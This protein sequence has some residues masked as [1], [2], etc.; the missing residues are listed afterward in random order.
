M[1]NDSPV[2]KSIVVYD[3]S[4]LYPAPLRD[5]LMWLA[6]ADLFYAKWTD[7]IHD[8]WTRSVLEDRPDLTREKLDRTRQL[9]NVKV[10]DALVVGYEPWIERLV[11]PDVDDRHVL[12]AAIEAQADVI[13]TF[14]LKDFPPPVLN[15]Y[16]IQAQHPDEFIRDLIEQSSK[17]VL[18]AVRNHHDSLQRP[19]KTKAQYLETLRKQ[20]LQHAAELIERL[21]V[22]A[23]D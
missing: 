10:P 5:L 18:E 11:L 1:K 2:E 8:E 22:D 13:V 23:I 17:A 4:V 9:M 14:N 12:A 20:R 15:P 19:P 21:W 16:Q 7:A 3:S 6:L